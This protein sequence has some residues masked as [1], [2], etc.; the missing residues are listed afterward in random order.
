MQI[1]HWSFIGVSLDKTLPPALNK[2]DPLPV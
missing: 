2:Y 1:N